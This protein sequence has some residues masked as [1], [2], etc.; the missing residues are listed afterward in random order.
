MGWSNYIVIDEY[1]IKVEIS[2]NVRED[3]MYTLLEN[4][5]QLFKYKEELSGHEINFTD[6]INERAKDTLKQISYSVYDII[7]ECMEEEWFYD[8]TFIAWL[9]TRNI[10]YRFLTEFELEGDKAEDYTNVGRYQI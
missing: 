6:K 8:I 2:R 1:K 3:M 4:I 9:K 7:V 5:P 10:S